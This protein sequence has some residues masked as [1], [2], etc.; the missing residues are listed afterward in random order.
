MLK[1]KKTTKDN[2]LIKKLSQDR[3]TRKIIITN[4]LFKK[5]KLASLQRDKSLY[6]L[7]NQA[8]QTNL[9]Q[10]IDLS[11]TNSNESDYK[12][13][14]MNA[15]IFKQVKQHCIENDISLKVFLHQS[16]VSILT[17]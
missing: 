7:L 11:I 1:P 14:A 17:K 10:K 9:N 4:E 6:E 2:A 15:L 8:L 16:L 5:I 13:F 3:V 12:N